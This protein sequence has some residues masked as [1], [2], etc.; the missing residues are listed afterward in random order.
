MPTDSG[1]L[2]KQH[3]H[4]YA[5]VQQ[6]QAERNRPERGAAWPEAQRSSSASAV[7]MA[8]RCDTHG[9]RLDSRAGA[10]PN[11]RE[12]AVN[13]QVPGL[14]AW[15]PCRLRR[16]GSYVEP[17]APHK[18]SSQQLQQARAEYRQHMKEVVAKR[19]EEDIM[20]ARHDAHW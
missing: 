3:A 14:T 1:S 10:L 2:R 13:H 9:A 11:A 6:E 17:V 5:Q 18:T 8:E 19:I 12:T 20:L 7:H 4:S 16:H 15:Q